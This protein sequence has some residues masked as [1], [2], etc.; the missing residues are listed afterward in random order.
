MSRKPKYSS[1][2]E[3]LG[4]YSG[5]FEPIELRDLDSALRTGLADEIAMLRVSMRRVF[6]LT[7]DPRNP[8][9]AEKALGTLGLAA[10]RLAKLLQV[11]REMTGSNSSAYEA[12]N[13]A[14]SQVLDEMRSEGSPPR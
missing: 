7:S 4:F 13:E 5:G 2:P 1:E 11:E 3:Q 8:G 14:I 9:R 10:T 12:I 6:E